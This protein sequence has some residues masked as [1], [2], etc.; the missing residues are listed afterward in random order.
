MSDHAALAIMAPEDPPPVAIHNAKAS[1]PFLLLGDHAGNAIPARLEMLGLE[2]DD[3]ARHIAID[4]GVR[5]L[6]MILSQLLDAPFVHQHYSRLVIDCNR[7]PTSAEAIPLVS[8]GTTIAGNVGAD[9]AARVAA[10]HAPYHAAIDTVLEARSQAGRETILL[11]L[12]SFTPVMGGTARPWHVGILHGGGDVGFAAA[13]LGALGTES[14]IIVG[15]NEPYRM[16]DTDYTV[17][18]HAFPRGLPYAEIEVRQDLIGDDVGQAEWGERLAR[19][20][21]AALA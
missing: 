11:A 19:A 7:D 2:A 9:A 12:H 6:G 10:I 16:D 4:I 15:D 18:R 8:D 1:S 14:G 3:R 21:R 17:P 20:A 13:M 5:G